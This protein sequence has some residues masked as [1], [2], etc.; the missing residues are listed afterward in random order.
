MSVQATEL[1]I[2]FAERTGLTGEHKP[3]RYLWTD[4]FAV[5]NFLGCHRE[6]GD[7]RALVLARAL[8]DQVHHTLGRHRS[9]DRRTGWISGLPEA[10]GEHHPTLGG[11]RIGKPHPER[12]PGEPLD[13]EA[14]WDRDGQYF[15]YLTKWMHA[16]DQ[17]SRATGEPRYGTWARELGETAYRRFVYGDRAPRMYWKMSIDLQR[18]LVTSMGHHDPLDGYLSCTQLATSAAPGPDLADARRDFARMIDRTSLG[19]ADPLGIGGLLADAHRASVL[20]QE[21]PLIAAILD[22]AELGLRRYVDRPDLHAPAAQRL[23][24][25]ELGLAIGLAAVASLESAVTARFARFLPLRDELT[26]FWSRPEH[27]R[28]RVWLE[29]ADINDVML[30]TSLAPEGYLTRA[31]LRAR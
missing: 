8:V 26:A 19:T 20:D 23:A 2:Q 24:F 18:P 28:T 22:G 11:L 9:D 21:R 13:E 5:C 17:I 16:L 3:R 1:M 12:A 25:R 27:R 30:A 15:H 29:H 6:T 7:P 4:A 10:D 14:E 31:T